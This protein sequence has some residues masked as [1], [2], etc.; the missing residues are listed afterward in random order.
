LKS[1]NY[2]LVKLFFGWWVGLGA[3]G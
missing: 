2:F 3:L 1:A